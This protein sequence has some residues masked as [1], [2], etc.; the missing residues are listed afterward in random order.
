MM[1]R[2]RAVDSLNDE[3]PM[4][5]PTITR[6]IRGL[7]LLLMIL[8]EAAGGNALPPSS[9]SRAFEWTFESQKT[10]ADPFNDVDVDVIFTKDGESWRVPTFWRG[11]SKWTV[12]FAP[13]TP[14][15]YTYRLESTDPSNSDL[16]G[17]PGRVN[18]TAYV[19]SNGLLR[20]GML[21]VSANKRYFEHADGTPFYWLGD[22]WWTGMS[23]RLSWE[24]FQKLTADRKAKGFTVVQFVAG[25][26][27]SDEE[28]APIDPGFYN[29]GGAVWDPEFKRINPKFFDYA[30]RRVQ[31]L[32]DSGIAPAIVGAWVQALR[33][34]GTAKMKQHWRYI[35]ARYGAYPVFWIV[36]GEV[37]DPPE[38]PGRKLSPFFG[39]A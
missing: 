35:I 26:I 12:R 13:P 10:Y 37:Y 7:M 22:T 11:G 9:Q 29:E 1:Y 36:G 15:E 18:I 14:G 32:I 16:N 27:P 8:I 20:H 4:R 23:D 34:M 2:V 39:Q 3:T 17:H 5:R 28:V 25:L 38:K 21:R 24:G 31:H 19:G 30:D 6:A 33:Q